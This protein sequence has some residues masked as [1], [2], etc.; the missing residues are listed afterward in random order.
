MISDENKNKIVKGYVEYKN[1]K[2]FFTFEDWELSLYPVEGLK[3][4]LFS[5]INAINSRKDQILEITSIKGYTTDKKAIEFYGFDSGLKD[6]GEIDFDINYY[7]VG[8]RYIEDINIDK[9][10]IYSNIFKYLFPSIKGATIKEDNTTE[11]CKIYDKLDYGYD[12]E[13][14]IKIFASSSEYISML[15]VIP[16]KYEN[17]LGIEFDKSI[18]FNKVLNYFYTVKNSLR[19]ILNTNDVGEFYIRIPFTYEEEF[20]EKKNRITDYLSIKIKSN[21]INVK[22][23]IEKRNFFHIL[24]GNFIKLIKNIHNGNIYIENIIN[25]NRD[26]SYDI[27]RIILDFAAI[28]NLTKINIEEYRKKYENIYFY[29]KSDKKFEFKSSLK[30]LYDEFNNLIEEK[31]RFEDIEKVTTELTDLRNAVSHGDLDLDVSWNNIEYLSVYEKIIYIGVLSYCNFDIETIKELT[32]K[33]F[34]R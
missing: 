25:R 16:F 1:K 22:K 6:D 30:I 18:D 10:Y 14:G 33:V 5:F 17:Y 27:S 13:E 31:E 24:N 15:D 2:F 28:E 4:D 12:K 23:K 29:K 7:I 3:Q 9:M 11:L 26:N 34:K 19:Y 32:K 8:D 20:R 21:N